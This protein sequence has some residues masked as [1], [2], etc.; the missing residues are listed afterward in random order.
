[1]ANN[2]G[3]LWNHVKSK[4]KKQD[5]DD[6][7]PGFWKRL[8]DGFCEVVIDVAEVVV[9]VAVT[10]IVDA[11]GFVAEVI[12]PNNNSNIFGFNFDVVEGINGAGDWSGEVWD[13]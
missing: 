4:T 1:M 2:P 5:G 3:H 11:I 9:Q 10:P 12:Q 8:W 6:P 13:W 7:K